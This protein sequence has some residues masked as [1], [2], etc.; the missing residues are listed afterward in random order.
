MLV[1]E[2]NPQCAAWY[3][4][5]CKIRTP[6]LAAPLTIILY[7]SKRNGT[8]REVRRRMCCEECV[9]HL[10]PLEPCHAR[11]GKWSVSIGSWKTHSSQHNSEHFRFKHSLKQNT[12]IA[13]M[14]TFCINSRYQCGNVNALD[15]LTTGSMSSKNRRR[16][17]D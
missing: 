14:I 8:I 3:T 13:P 15:T 1:S 17:C 10:F 16:D 9:V 2:R 4:T 6:Y 12:N 11:I 5:K 7:E